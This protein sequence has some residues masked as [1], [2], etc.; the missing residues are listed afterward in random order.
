MN[1]YDT[2]TCAS[3]CNDITG[4]VAFNIYFERDPS[5]DPNAQQCPNPPSVTNIKCVWW[6]VPVSKSTAT[7]SGQY[8][9]SFE[10][11]IAGSNGYNAI[12]EPAEVA[13]FSAGVSYGGA[14]NVPNDPVDNQDTYI[15]SK[16]Y[17]YGYGPYQIQYY[18]PEVCVHACADQTAYDYNNPPSS[19]RP[20]VCNQVVA[21]SLNRN[22]VPQGMY[23]S[24][25]TES[26]GPN[27]GTTNYVVYAGSVYT[28]D[29]VF[30]Y[31]NSTYAASYNEIGQ[32]SYQGGSCGGYGPGTC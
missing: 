11:V 7:N 18:A 24:F 5:L 3:K 19:G 1:S 12:I 9:D 20:A 17:S 30:S 29:N 32:N 26:W 6:G 15:T 14:L 10:V 22:G 21:L 25:F 23:C 16:F 4:C 8:R 2:L 28:V 13:G 31:V 27:Y